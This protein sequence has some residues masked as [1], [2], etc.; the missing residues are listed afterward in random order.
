[1]NTEICFL[2]FAPLLASGLSMGRHSSRH[3]KNANKKNALLAIENGRDFLL[4]PFIDVFGVGLD[5][6]GQKYRRPLSFRLCG[7][8]E[9]QD[10]IK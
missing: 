3:D 8:R 10:L 9:V 2:F 7:W 1:V 6:A 4:L 5:Q